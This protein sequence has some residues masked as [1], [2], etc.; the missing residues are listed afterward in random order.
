MKTRD[1]TFLAKWNAERSIYDALGK[2]LIVEIIRGVED[3]QPR[4]VDN[5]FK[6]PPACR[7]KEPPSLLEK[8]FY[9]SEKKYSDPYTDITDKV[10]VRFV[11]LLGSELRIIENAL[12]QIADFDFSKDRDYEEEQNKNPIVFDYAAIHYVVRPKADINFNGVIIPSGTPCEVQIKSM[13]QHAYSELTHDTIYKPQIQQTSSMYR[14]AAKAQALLEATN[15]YF[16]KVNDE[17]AEALANVRSMT[18]TLSQLY[19]DLVSLPA[20]PTL[21]E[22]I[23]LD[24]YETKA[25]PDYPSAIRELFSEKAFLSENIRERAAQENPIFRQPAVLLVY[26][27][28][29][30]RRER[31]LEDWPLTPIEMEPLLND[32]GQ[33]AGI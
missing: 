6:I 18:Q 1:Q 5:F 25:E 10:G 21:L 11:A 14:N 28:I 23:L 19:L 24:R 29:Y 3:A 4:S 17:V 12:Q 7:T 22:G 27:D 26:L 2:F 30:R 32:L 8:A 20:Q 16:E 15:D 31:S 9:R 13:L 33:S